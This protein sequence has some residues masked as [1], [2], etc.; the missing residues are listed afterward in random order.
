MVFSALSYDFKVKTICF[1]RLFHMVFLWYGVYSLAM[2][3]YSSIFDQAITGPV[4]RS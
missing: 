2:A 4:L 1:M 3:D